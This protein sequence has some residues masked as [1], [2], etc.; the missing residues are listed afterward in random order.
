MYKKRRN[1]ELARIPAH[2]GE[3]PSY[4]K[5][6]ATGKSTAKGM[7]LQQHSLLT[8]LLSKTPVKHDF[9]PN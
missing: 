5:P 1:G 6:T 3:A 4:G 2:H 9:Q 7:I 8:S